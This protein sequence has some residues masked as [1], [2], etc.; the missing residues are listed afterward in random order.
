M[1]GQQADTGGTSVMELKLKDLVFDTIH[2]VEVVE[3]LMKRSVKSTQDWYWQKQLRCR[4]CL[5]NVEMS[6]IF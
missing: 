2:H 4:G 1:P 6:L 5:F 3:V